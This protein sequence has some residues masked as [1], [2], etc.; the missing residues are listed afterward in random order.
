MAVETF[1]YGDRR[2]IMKKSR[3]LSVIVLA[4]CL[5]LTSFPVSAYAATPGQARSAEEVHYGSVTPAE[6]EEIRTMFDAEYYAANNEDVVSQC[7]TDANKLFNHFITAGLFEGRACNK[8]FNVSAYRSSYA[9][10]DEAFGDDLV[11]YYLH[12]LRHGKSEV[13]N[14]TLTT[15]EKAVKAGKTVR[16][17]VNPSVV[18]AEPAPVPAPTPTYTPTPT[19]SQNDTSAQKAAEEA[20]KA[21][22]TRKEVGVY[23]GQQGMLTYDANNRI[24]YAELNRIN[25][26]I[27]YDVAGK[28]IRNICKDK[29]GNIVEVLEFSY[30]K[31]GNRISYTSKD[32]DGNITGICE[33]GYDKN[34]N[35]IKSTFKDK[36]GNIT[37]YRDVVWNN[38]VAIKATYKDKDGNVTEIDEYTNNGINS[39][40][41]VYVKDSN[42][43][44]IYE[45]NAKGITC[46]C[47]GYDEAG[48][49]EY[50]CEY[51]EAGKIVRETDYSEGRVTSIWEFN[52][53]GKTSGATF[54]DEAGNISGFLECKYDANGN[55]T[56]NIYKDQYGNVTEIWKYDAQGNYTVEVPEP[57][58]GQEVTVW[59]TNKISTP[60]DINNYQFYNRVDFTFEVRNNTSKV[61]K[62]VLG[63]LKISDLFGTEIKTL[64]LSFTGKE[65]EPHKTESYGKMG[66][67]INQ[68]RDED[69]KLYNEKFEDLRF[70]YTITDIVYASDSQGGTTRTVGDGS[71]FITVNVTEKKNIDQDIMSGILYNYCRFTVKVSNRGTKDIK[72]IQGT[73]VIKDLYGNTKIKG[74]ISFT[75]T[76]I[77]AGYTVTFSDKNI[78]LN[79]FKDEDN[80][81]WSQ[82]HDDMQ[83]E[84]TITDIVYAD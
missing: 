24:I 76:N 62:G 79:D 31:N 35:R 54:K 73:L 40:T 41:T 7:G 1:N 83:Y 13:E 12:Y 37:G 36:D 17:A 18:V 15:V 33:Y 42:I 38:G 19:P 58:A 78:K 80:W 10:L 57:E 3:L 84:F 72:G 11:K 44:E 26:E 55:K 69:I 63:T 66:I 60:E 6:S 29:S 14:R 81:L 77:P 50:V 67:N 65:I 51:D 48:N 9:D 59:V 8:D 82:K 4:G 27:E 5:A 30:D 25:C 21:D 34:G 75:G 68:F 22:A 45:Y 43:S 20:Q 39:K 70:E 47:T 28:E 49:I 46:K 32:K 2:K 53:N 71:D 23:N 74:S 64:S 52:S 56:E 61:I 16:S